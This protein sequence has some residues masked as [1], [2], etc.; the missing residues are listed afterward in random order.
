VRPLKC[1]ISLIGR[2]PNSP[3]PT[4]A[5]VSYANVRLKSSTLTSAEARKPNPP[6]N[7]ASQG[8]LSIIRTSEVGHR[9][10]EPRGPTTEYFL[11]CFVTWEALRSIGSRIIAIGSC[12][13]VLRFQEHGNGVH[14][15][16]R[17]Q[18]CSEM[19]TVVLLCKKTGLSYDYGSISISFF[20]CLQIRHLR[21]VIIHFVPAST[22]RRKCKT[23]PTLCP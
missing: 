18:P 13:Y 12:R 21:L 23:R 2:Q 4:S 7:S 1:L 9:T 5:L 14:G 20:F 16:L 10:C 19:V 6:K 15:A 17:R 22:C 3:K 11:A 8:Y